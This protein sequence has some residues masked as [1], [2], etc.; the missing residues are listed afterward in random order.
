MAQDTASLT[1]DR[2]G[3]REDLTDIITNISPRKTPMFS[4]F[5]K[6]KADGMYHEFQTDTL[7]SAAKNAHIESATFTFSKAPTRTRVGSYVQLFETPVSVS[8]LQRKVKT[9][10]VKDEFVYQ[11]NKGLKEHARDI[12]YALINGTGASGASGAARE[13]KGTLAWITTN[14]ETGTGTGDEALTES[15]FNDLLQAIWAQ[16]GE[17]DTAYA[18]GF[19]KRKISAFTGGSTKNVQADEK[20]IWAGVDVYDSD[21]GRIKII[22]HHMMTTSVVAVLQDSLWKVAMFDTTHK[23][24][25]A[26]VASST[27]AVITTALTLES[28]QEAGSGKLTELTTS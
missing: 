22:P 12:E 18:N 2:V 24:D 19:Q 17:P 25:V 20:V 6:T 10:G 28:R 13:L 4:R 15:M 7:A 8:D 21:F 26:K 9:A 14:V 3:N 5:G 27:D 1:F 11:M 16:G 23:V